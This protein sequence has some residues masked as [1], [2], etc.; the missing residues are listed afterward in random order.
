MLRDMKNSLP[1][2]VKNPFKL[3]DNEELKCSNFVNQSIDIKVT[4]NKKQEEKR[5]QK[6][7]LIR[8]KSK[9]A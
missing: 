6:E 4:S 1:D 9:S 2:W 7:V 8:S 3:D 5:K